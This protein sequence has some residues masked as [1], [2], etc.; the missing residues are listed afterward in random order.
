MR[1]ETQGPGEPTGV[2]AA[3]AR[4]LRKPTGAGL[5]DCKSALGETGGDGIEKTE[6]GFASEVA[7]AL[8]IS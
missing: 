3:T 8:G 2:A 5:M 7:A 6:A 4:E 1:I